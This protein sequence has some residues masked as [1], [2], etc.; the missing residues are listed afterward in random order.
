M[1]QISIQFKDNLNRSQQ[2][3]ASTSCHFFER[4]DSRLKIQTTWRLIRHDRQSTL[5]VTL[6]Q[7]NEQL[8]SSV[9]S[10][11]HQTREIEEDNVLAA[12][13]CGDDYESFDDW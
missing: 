6:S 13:L 11:H 4:W 12:F 3:R 7:S 1:P 5:S 8:S 9:S 10:S 2:R